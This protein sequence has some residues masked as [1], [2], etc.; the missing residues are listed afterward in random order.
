M[1]QIEGFMV[2]W[3]DVTDIGSRSAFFSHEDYADPMGEA[4]KLMAELRIEPQNQFVTM[5]SQNKNS[6]GKSGVDSIVDGKTPDGYAYEWSKAGRAGKMKR[7]RHA[8]S[9]S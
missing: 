7:S 1:E 8:A 5:A 9:S 2:F 4:M 3:I 6:V